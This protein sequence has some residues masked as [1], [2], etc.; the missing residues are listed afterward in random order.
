MHLTYSVELIS[1]IT[2]IKHN[3]VQYLVNLDEEI[4]SRYIS[5]STFR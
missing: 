5:K 4:D 3:L 1:F 2:T